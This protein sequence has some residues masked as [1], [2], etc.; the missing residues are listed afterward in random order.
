MGLRGGAQFA[1]GQRRIGHVTTVYRARWGPADPVL[2]IARKERV[3][4]RPRLA[5]WPWRSHDT[6]GR[7]LV[8]GGPCLYRA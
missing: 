2:R 5:S 4:I 7:M 6:P 3:I 8:N 1:R